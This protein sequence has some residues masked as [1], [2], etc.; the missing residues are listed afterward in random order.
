MLQHLGDL[1]VFGGHFFLCA[2]A[3]MRGTTLLV[4]SGSPV[5]PQAVSLATTKMTSSSS[6]ATIRC[7]AFAEI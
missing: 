5:M 3:Q 6:V 7:S 1:F 4:S 2:F